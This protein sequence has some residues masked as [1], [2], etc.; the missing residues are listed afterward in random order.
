MLRL[1]GWR[2]NRKRVYRLWKQEGLKVPSKQHKRRRQGHSEN[3]ILR[4][5]PEHKDQ[6]WALD[7]I[8][9]RDAPGPALEVAERGG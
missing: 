3:G 9:D 2:V 8:H 5:R 4:R 6:V 7:F 1:E